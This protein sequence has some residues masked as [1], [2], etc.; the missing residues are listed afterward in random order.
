MGGIGKTTLAKIIHNQL[1]NKFVHVSFLPDVRETTRR[2]GITYLQSQLISDIL[3][4]KNEV[5]RI[6]DGINI[7]KSRFRQKEVLILL[8]DIDDKNQL[9]ALVRKHNWFMAGSLIIVTTR[10]KAV[11]DQSEFEVDY[12]YELNGLD[13]VHALLL[14]N[15]HAFRMDHSPKDFDGISRDIIFT[16]GGLPLALEVVGSYLYKKKDRGVWEEVRKQLKNQPHRDVQK[17]L[18][19]SYDALDDG[20]KQIFLDIACF[21]IDQRSEYAIYM[22]EDCGLYPNQ[23]IE[24]LKLRCLIKID[25]NGFFK[26]HGQVRDLGR[27]IFR[28]RLEKSSIPGDYDYE[29]FPRALINPEV[30]K[31]LKVLD[32]AFC[33]YLR[34]TP[35]LS[36]FTLLEILILKHCDGMEQ[37]HPSIG[38]VNSLVSLDLSDCGS[39]KEIPTS[40]SSLR[41]LEKLSARGCRLLREIPSSIG[42]LQNLRHLDISESAIEKLPNTIGR[43]MNLQTL[44]LESCQSLKGEIPSEIEIQ[45]HDFLNI[46]EEI[47]IDCCKSIERLILPELRCLKQLKANY[48]HNLVEIRGLDRAKSL[49]V[50]DISDCGSIERLPDLPC[51]LT[52]KELNINDCHNLRSVESLERFLSCRSIY[53]TGCKSLEKLPNLSKFEKLENFTMRYSLGVTKIPGVE[54]SRSLT[55]IDITGCESMETLPDLSRCEKLQSL[56]ISKMPLSPV[57]RGTYYDIPTDVD[58]ECMEHICVGAPGLMFV[59]VCVLVMYDVGLAN[60]PVI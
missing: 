23:G 36:A 25:Y 39:L 54:K 26:M 59:Q 14:F 50:L 43:L 30:A 8:D 5:S 55:H 41:K 6:D 19:I 34:C 31:R 40:I 4:S 60:G 56:L 53:I 33:N 17:I 10:N 2:H 49:E 44:S 20:D 52:L 32:L 13:K 28:Q 12:K 45:G 9:D 3:Q 35:D 11:L 42:D 58:V 7:I 57:V 1:L 24:E 51:F 48:C 46:L 47:V 22:W 15:R 38:R 29:G 21:L 18:Q 16:I 37:L 27:S